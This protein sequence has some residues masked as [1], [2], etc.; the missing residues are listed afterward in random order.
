[1]AKQQSKV[2]PPKPSLQD[3]KQYVPEHFSMVSAQRGHGHSEKA[4][5]SLKDD[6]ELNGYKPVPVKG[7]Y[8]YDEKAYLVPHKGTERDRRT[9]EM[10]GWK[11]DQESVLHSS[12]DKHKLVF[13]QK[14]GEPK[15][16][17]WTGEGGK[18]G[19]HKSHYTELPDG[20]KIQLL[21]QPPKDVKKSAKW[22]LPIDDL[23]KAF[24]HNDGATKTDVVAH[25]TALAHL[26]PELMKWGTENLVPMEQDEKGIFELG[27]HTV[28][29]RKHM[30][31]L[32]SG[33]LEKDNEINHRFDR[34][35]MPELLGQL[36]SKLEMYGPPKSLEINDETHIEP[37]G[38]IGMKPKDF[39]E[40]HEKIVP[41]L[42]GAG[43]TEEAKEQAQELGDVKAKLE[44]LKESMKGPKEDAVE[45]PV[46]DIIGAPLV[47]ECI[48]C[49]QP[50]SQCS[51]FSNLPKPRLEFD[52]KVVRVFFKSESWSTEDQENFCN[53]FKGY[54]GKS[55]LK[56]TA[57]KVMAARDDIRKRLK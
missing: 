17:E 10:L 39:I 4:H 9:V 27:G 7:N 29:V 19:N 44:Q 26:P 46:K 50:M 5:G 1:M 15:Q 43:L 28:K 42:K 13:R 51:C 16:P 37:D 6:L 40:E 22:A 32:Y 54:V 49:E 11:H 23:A 38:D 52:G 21:V 14:H 41:D 31:D 55:L 20:K 34:A 48:A 57:E 47:N 36:Q 45:M 24:L 12:S 2:K 56:K 8:G 18:I 35:T 3:Y 53:D 25:N 33:W 30:A